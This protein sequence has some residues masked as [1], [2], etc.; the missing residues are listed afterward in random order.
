MKFLPQR[1]SYAGIYTVSVRVSLLNASLVTLVL[2]P[3]LVV[4]EST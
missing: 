3:D 1:E 4:S 2:V